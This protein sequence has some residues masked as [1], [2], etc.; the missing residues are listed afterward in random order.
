MQTIR[1]TKQL[2]EIQISHLDLHDSNI[3]FVLEQ[4][5]ILVNIDY[6]KCVWL[7]K[8]T[9]LT[10][11][12]SNPYLF[13]KELAELQHRLPTSNLYIALAAICKIRKWKVLDVIK[14][15]RKQACYNRWKHTELTA[16]LVLK[17]H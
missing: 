4:D 9:R 8:C 15:L 7:D 14:E 2:S 10:G 5:R 13:G 17:Q 1:I 6:G 11:C 12:N 16:K 3:L